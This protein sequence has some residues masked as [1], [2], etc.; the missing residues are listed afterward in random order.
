MIQRQTRLE[1]MDNS[2]VQEVVCIG[3]DKSKSIASLGDRI[4]VVVKR[5]RGQR[6]IPVGEV[7]KALVV[8]TTRG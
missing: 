4:T 6:R 1:V 3:I 8:R 5:I 2:G 7:V